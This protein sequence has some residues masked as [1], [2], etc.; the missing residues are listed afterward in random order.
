MLQANT[1]SFHEISSDDGV[2]IVN[3][4]CD[5]CERFSES[6]DYK[7]A[8][9]PGIEWISNRTLEAMNNCLDQDDCIEFEDEEW[10]YVLTISLIRFSVFWHD[11]NDI[12]ALRAR[13]FDDLTA[14]SSMEQH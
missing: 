3:K 6:E 4:V 1:L 5:F 12:E 9:Q 8:Y 14:C 10:T 11:E 2:R 7:K 13:L